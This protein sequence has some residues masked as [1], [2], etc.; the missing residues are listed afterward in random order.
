VALVERRIGLLFAVFLGLLAIAAL[1]SL[2]LGTLRGGALSAAAS[3]QQVQTNVVP[4]QRGTITDRNGVELAVSQ[5][6]DDVS[7]TPYLIKDP[8]RAATKLAPLLG[9]DQDA[10][11]RKLTLRDTGFVYL[12]RKLPAARAD[13]IRKLGIA[14]IDLAPTQRRT[15]PRDYLASQV[16]G[17]VGTDGEGL[18]GLEY[19][20]DGRLRGADGERRIV[21]DGVGD[22]VAV[23]DLKTARAGAGVQLTLDSN[24]Q[25]K[26]EDVLKGVGEA[27]RPKGATAV[28]M[29]PQTGEILALANWP[30]IDANRP[31]AAP[32]YANQDRAVGYTYEPGST[33]KAFTVA[34]ALDDGRVTPDTAF[35]L[36][37][38]ITLYDRTIGNAHARGWATMT[39]AQIL[40]QSDNVGAIT[41]GQRLGAKRFDWWV[42]RFG[43]GRPTG[44]QLPGEERG[45]VLPLDKYSGSSMGNLPIGQGEAVTSMQIAQAYAAIANGGIL[46]RPSILR[47]LDGEPVARPA[48]KRIISAHTAAALR[49]ML[50]G[51]LA[52]GGTASEV[53]IPGY[54]LAGKT[55]TA[56]KVDTTTGEYS[57]TR[58][59][60]SF[61]GFAPADHPKL[62]ISI[63]VDEP[64]GGTYAGGQVAAPAFGKIASF[65]LPYLDIPPK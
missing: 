36:P 60:A 1:R 41:I 23:R 21:R 17:S 16:L 12:A 28:V 11:L 64:Q 46:R 47:S 38:Q 20:L 26:T 34:G 8:V 49:G 6:A 55:G 14:G 5:P 39:T 22:D 42:R 32:G 62:L 3:S 10:L 52:P 61:V 31:T 35:N 51:V 29:N 53:H 4:A 63:M 2:Q 24:I 15:Y 57:N 30:Q 45:I 58:Y 50:K 48:G 56:N 19:E 54:E 33:F 43:F 37:P 65:A 59:V 13:A 9:V 25:D 18:S 7:A 44:I 40:A 27:F